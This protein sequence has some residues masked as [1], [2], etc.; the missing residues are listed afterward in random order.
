MSKN[1]GRL[2]GVEAFLKSEVQTMFLLEWCKVSLIDGCIFQVGIFFQI[3]K[4]TL[5][6]FL[7]I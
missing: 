7:P 3:L 6:Y 2:V 1:Y 5:H 4:K